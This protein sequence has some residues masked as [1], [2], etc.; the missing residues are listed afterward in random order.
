MS[1]SNRFA[2]LASSYS[3]SSSDDGNAVTASANPPAAPNN[4]G[5][6]ASGAQLVTTTRQELLLTSPSGSSAGGLGASPPRVA[7]LIHGLD[8]TPSTEDTHAARTANV[9]DFNN[10]REPPTL[11]EMDIQIAIQQGAHILVPETQAAD[12]TA[13]QAT[14][15]VR[16]VNRNVREINS[17]RAGAPAV[18]VRTRARRGTIFVNP[19]A[20]IR[21]D[22]GM[23]AAGGHAQV[24][25]HGPLPPSSQAPVFVVKTEPEERFNQRVLAA[26]QTRRN[27]RSAAP[28][29]SPTHSH[30]GSTLSAAID[31]DAPRA[32]TASSGTGPAGSR[33]PDADADVRM[34]DAGDIFSPIH[35]AQPRREDTVDP[36]PVRLAARTDGLIQTVP[37]ATNRERAVMTTFAPE[38]ARSTMSFKPFGP[39]EAIDGIPCDAH[40]RGVSPERVAHF[41]NKPGEKIVHWIYTMFGKLATAYQ[42]EDLVNHLQ[43]TWDTTFPG[44]VNNCVF[45]ADLF[46][47]RN[48]PP[49][50]R[51]RAVT[52]VSY[53]LHA[54]QAEIVTQ[55]RGI[56]W[57]P[58]QMLVYRWPDMESIWGGSF[59]GIRSNDEDIMTGLVLDAVEASPIV[60]ACIRR[61]AEEDQI[62]AGGLLDIV[63]G[64]I[65]LT[66]MEVMRPRSTKVIHQWNVYADIRELFSEREA[67]VMYAAFANLDIQD[68]D[69]GNSTPIKWGC[70]FC[71]SLSHPTGKC[72]ATI[73][74]G[75]KEFA[76]NSTPAA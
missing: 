27:R 40:L 52:I 76:Q 63:L 15:H 35:G 48:A 67:A 65:R 23:D 3:S 5:A 8:L 74:G 9:N 73:L 19:L 6:A 4:A 37:I 16:E 33:G 26:P 14:E 61:Q 68:N 75:W 13:G 57:G 51:V 24:E 60:T 71:R 2:N 34:A 10:N 54:R 47:A 45:C 12:G 20:T 42:H 44:F 46:S 38:L 25:I 69:L 7:G 32:R 1:T 31:V 29:P 30:A 66:S 43:H 22:E 28:E 21:E 50:K 64:R 62:E 49:G 18:V 11:D 55:C 53:G 41:E 59:Y 39:M 56:N 36:E 70:R 58:F 72:F 17:G